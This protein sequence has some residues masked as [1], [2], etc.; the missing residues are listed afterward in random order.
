MAGNMFAQL[1]LL[2]GNRKTKFDLGI[3]PLK[4]DYGGH[5]HKKFRVV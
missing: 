1:M 5:Q 2:E 3:T 4:R